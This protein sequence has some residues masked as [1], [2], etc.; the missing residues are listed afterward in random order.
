MLN[1]PNY[2]TSVANIL[3]R[4]WNPYYLEIQNHIRQ[5][6]KTWLSQIPLEK[7]NMG[8]AES[9]ALKCVE[10]VERK[11]SAILVQNSWK[12][13]YTSCWSVQLETW[14]TFAL[15]GTILD[16]AEHVVNSVCPE[17]CPGQVKWF[18]LLAILWISRVLKEGKILLLHHSPC[19]T[20]CVQQYICLFL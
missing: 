8:K 6:C 17:D 16:V 11:L 3:I 5:C 4:P 9:Q 7:Q 10:S 1:I 19:K 14:I 13:H 18:Q 15:G 20:G 2:K 12:S